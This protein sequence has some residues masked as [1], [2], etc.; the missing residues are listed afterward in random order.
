MFEVVPAFFCLKVKINEKMGV[1]T[2][3][4]PLYVFVD[5]KE[6]HK[7]RLSNIQHEF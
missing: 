3:F 4:Q 7:D 2:E 5:V 1:G 6:F